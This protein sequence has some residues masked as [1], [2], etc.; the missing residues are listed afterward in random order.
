MN[1]AAHALRHTSSP[2]GR[3]AS[4]VPQ[5][6]SSGVAYVGPLTLNLRKDLANKSPVVATAK[7]GDK[8][9]VLEVR[10]PFI[11][12]RTGQGDESSVDDIISK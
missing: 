1:A 5:Q 6:P 3:G 9:D 12:V 8:L 2:S 10:R 11:K 7:H 4:S